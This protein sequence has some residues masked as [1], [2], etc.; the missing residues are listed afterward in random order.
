MRLLADLSP[1]E[2][3]ECLRESLPFFDLIGGALYTNHL[4]GRTNTRRYLM[5]KQA[6]PAPDV[7]HAVTGARSHAGE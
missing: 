7:E 2:R 3:S 1:F 5:S 6:K 4:A